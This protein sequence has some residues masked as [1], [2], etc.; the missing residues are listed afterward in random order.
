MKNVNRI[1]YRDEYDFKGEERMGVLDKFKNKEKEPKQNEHVA[2][3]KKMIE[4]RWHR[5][6]KG[7]TK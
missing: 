6:C 2:A 5:N 7:E 4:S 1:T 3:Y